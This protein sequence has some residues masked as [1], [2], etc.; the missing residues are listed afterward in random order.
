MAILLIDMDGVVADF[1]EGHQR[2][3]RERGLPAHLEC[4]DR[5]VWDVLDVVG[6]EWRNTVMELWHS[7][8]F[9]A[10]LLPIPEAVETLHEWLRKGHKVFLCT[11]PLMNSETCAQEKI[12]W[13][14]QHVGPEFVRRTIITSDKTLVNGDIL[15]DDKPS[16]HGVALPSWKHL[17]YAARPNRNLHV[18]T[19]T[20]AQAK[21]YV[22]NLRVT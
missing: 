8:G 17:I 20:W 13:V 14:R 7:P 4:N 6:E 21:Q 12:S 22:S 19:F 11:A 9:F 15:L 10:G 16:I 3:C 2:M 5:E 18:G 1:D